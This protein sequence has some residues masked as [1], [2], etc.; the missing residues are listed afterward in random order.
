MPLGMRH[1]KKAYLHF[2]K[3]LRSLLGTKS[4]SARSPAPTL[5]HGAFSS[6]LAAGWGRNGLRW[7]QLRSMARCWAEKL[8]GGLTNHVAVPA[9]GW[10]PAR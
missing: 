3:R 8:V 10:A 6:Q 2:K 1:L 7:M 9:M 4:L 5:D